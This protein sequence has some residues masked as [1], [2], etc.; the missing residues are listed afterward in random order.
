VAPLAN[1]I[2]VAFI[3]GSIAEEH[4]RSESDVDLIIIG[5]VSGLDLT[6]ALQPF[7]DRL[8]CEVNFTRYTAKEFGSKISGPHC[9]VGKSFTAQLIMIKIKFY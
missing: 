6:S 8:G 1:K 2:H 5:D 3:H 7:Q 9:A 4:E